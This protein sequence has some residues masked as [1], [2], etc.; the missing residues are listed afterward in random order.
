MGMLTTNEQMAPFIPPEPEL[1]LPRTYEGCYEEIQSFLNGGMVGRRRLKKVLPSLFS[2]F[3][4]LTL[5]SKARILTDCGLSPLRTSNDVTFNLHEATAECLPPITP[6]VSSQDTRTET[7]F[8]GGSCSP[9]PSQTSL[10]SSLS[11][12]DEEAQ[13][14][15]K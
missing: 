13:G 10:L 6:V 11:G 1:A 7:V 4:I 15:S 5:E 3:G 8:S 12:S 14:E 9:Q 2:Y